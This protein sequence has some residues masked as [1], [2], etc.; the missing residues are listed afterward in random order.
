MVPC[1]LLRLVKI[2]EARVVYDW[3]LKL[4]KVIDQE[5]HL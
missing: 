1:E 3:N 4:N 2:L 5:Q